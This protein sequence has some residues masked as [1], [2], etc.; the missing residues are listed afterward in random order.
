M[1]TEQKFI[2]AYKNLKG[3]M[4]DMCKDRQDRPNSKE[5][6]Q[7]VIEFELAAM[8]LADELIKNT[9]S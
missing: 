1:N 4:K 3:M 8:D 7:S 6:K 9:K 2:N 5:Y